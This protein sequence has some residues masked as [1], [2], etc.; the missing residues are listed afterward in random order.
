MMTV[1]TTPGGW[2]CVSGADFGTEGAGKIRAAVRSEVP[3]RIEV[4]ADSPDGQAIAAMEIPACEENTEV[5]AVLS[6]QVAG[7][8]VVVKTMPGSANA[9][10]ETIDSLKWPEIIGTVAGDD[11][12]L[13]VIKPE[14]A[15]SDVAARMKVLSG[16]AGGNATC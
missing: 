16:V 14:S 3:G 11:T 13:A 4:A 15:A 5:E 8:L 6:V 9:A 1:S 2:V 12:I 10:C 7:N